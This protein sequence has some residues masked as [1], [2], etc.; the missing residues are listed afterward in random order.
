MYYFLFPENRKKSEFFYVSV[1]IKNLVKYQKNRCF[2][3]YWNLI[4]LYSLL[5]LW[6]LFFFSETMILIFFWCFNELNK[7]YRTK[8]WIFFYVKLFRPLL[9]SYVRRKFIKTYITLNSCLYSIFLYIF[10]LYI[11]FFEQRR[12]RKDIIRCTFTL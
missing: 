9:C 2:F 1:S 8:N 10:R 4:F 5:N 6:Y 12:R 11:E 7:L 3:V